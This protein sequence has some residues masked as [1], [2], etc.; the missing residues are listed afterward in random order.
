MTQFVEFPKMARLR[1]ECIIT[2]KIDGTNSSVC[3][4][5]DGQ[6]LAGSR[7]RWITPQDD[8]Y[9]FARWVEDH[10]GELMG[11]GVGVHF[12]E[13]WGSGCQ[14]GYDL[15]KG[16]KRWSLF[17]VARWCLASEEPQRIPTADPRI[18]KYQQPLPACCHLVPVL[19]R[20][21]FD[22]AR[23]DEA[24]ELLRTNGSLAS[25]GFMK[26]EGVVCFH[27]AGNCGFKTT[28]EKDQEW[29]GKS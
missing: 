1:R 15:Q 4:T 24:M 25:P 6:L 12:G 27:V 14:R 29:K 16:E 26:P 22:T 19:F 5:E 10:R 18:E 8:N 23:V 11:L 28:L 13:W 17:N 20:G 3:I 21:L 2:E 9:G 7:T